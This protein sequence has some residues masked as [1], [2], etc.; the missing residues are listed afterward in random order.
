[1]IDGEE[2]DGGTGIS[3]NES[4]LSH[5]LQFCHSCGG[6]YFF[7]SSHFVETNK[8][9]GVSTKLWS[10]IVT[11]MWPQIVAKLHAVSLTILCSHIIICH[12][13]TIFFEFKRSIRL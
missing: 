5:F 10:A 9:A 6:L 4:S 12:L 1:M 13:I 7:L 8:A 2:A 11:I 3:E